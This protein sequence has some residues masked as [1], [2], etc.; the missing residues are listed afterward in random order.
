MALAQTLQRAV[1]RVRATEEAALNLAQRQKVAAVADDLAATEA[2][3]KDALN[4]QGRCLLDGRRSLREKV[5]DASEKVRASLAQKP[6]P[7]AVSWWFALSEAVEALD[8]AAEQ[9]AALAETQPAGAPAAALGREVVAQLD[10]H[11]E[12][13]LTEAERWVG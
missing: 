6:E 7:G 5:K 10:A 3:L 9:V 2:A 13:L 4:A 11:R 12:A 1:T 8:E